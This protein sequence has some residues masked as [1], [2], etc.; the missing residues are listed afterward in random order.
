MSIIIH[1]LLGFI[2]S[3]LGTIF[4]SMLSMT[5][6]KISIQES[7]LKARN[8]AFGVSSVVVVQAFIAVEFSKLLMNNPEYI[9]TLQKAGIVVFAGLSIYFFS[10]KRKGNESKERKIEVSGFVKGL[11]FSS[12][13][14]F[15]IPF[16]FAV[17]TGLVL[18]QLYEIKTLNNLSFVFG[19]AA[20]TFALLYLY[21]YFGKYIERRV[22]KLSNNMDF[23]LGLLTAIVTIVNL[24]DVIT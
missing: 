10:Q 9:T 24:V 13:N 22:Q 21:A 19:S 16:Y 14:M 4:P 18:V 12:L 6:V 5:T 3:F 11:I 23:I 17:L 2:I 15:A 8:F 20:G 7:F 1:L